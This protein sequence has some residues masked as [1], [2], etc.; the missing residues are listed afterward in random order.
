MFPS[1]GWKFLKLQNNAIAL[2]NSCMSSPVIAIPAAFKLVKDAVILV[3]RAQ[4]APQVL[5]NL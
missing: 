5:M 1:Q 2:T 3:E 4:L